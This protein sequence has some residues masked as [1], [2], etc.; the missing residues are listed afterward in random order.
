MTKTTSKNTHATGLGYERG[1]VAR[2]FGIVLRI[3]RRRQGLSQDRLS[4]RSDHDRTYPS[5][6][7][8]GLRA[9]SLSMFLDILR[10]RWECHRTTP[11]RHSHTVAWRSYHRKGG[12]KPG[13]SAPN[14]Y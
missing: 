8:R 2:A 3:T 10:R 5:L 13:R 9:P 14:A 6:L 7:E 1:R 11:S 12:R 4:E